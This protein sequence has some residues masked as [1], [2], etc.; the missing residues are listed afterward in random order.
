MAICIQLARSHA[1]HYHLQLQHMNWTPCSLLLRHIS[2]SGREGNPIAVHTSQHTSGAL[3]LRIE[4]EGS[5]PV[6]HRALAHAIDFSVPI[7]TVR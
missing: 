6:L 7:E 4:A 5:L 3:V 1:Q 2:D